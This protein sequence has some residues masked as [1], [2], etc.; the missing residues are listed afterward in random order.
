MM[1]KFSK[2]GKGIGAWGKTTEET[3]HPDRGRAEKMAVR[4]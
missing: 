4:R 1:A 2:Q 3:G